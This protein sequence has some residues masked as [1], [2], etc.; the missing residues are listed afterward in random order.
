M[1]RFQYLLLVLAIALLAACKPTTSIARQNSSEADAT[2]SSD[3]FGLAGGTSGKGTPSML[4]ELGAGWI[5]I[6]VNWAQ[7]EPRPGKYNWEQVSNSVRSLAR[8]QPGVSVLVTLRAKSQWAGRGARGAPEKA[9]VPPR[10]LNAYY[11]F[12]YGMA[13][14]GKGIVKCWQ[15]ENEIESQTWWAGTPEEYIALLETA[16]R[17]IRAAD[18]SAK[19]MLAGFTS[20]MTTAAALLADGASKQEIA[21]RL[22]AKEDISDAKAEK[23]VRR[24]VDFIEAVLAQAKDLFDI[25]DIH[26]YNDYDTIPLRVEWLRG[27]MKANGYERP[28]WATEVGGPDT[29][30]ASF[31]ETYQAQEIIKRFALA[32]SAGVEKV[33]WLGLTELEG[34]GERFNHLG[35]VTRSGRKKLAYRAYQLTVAKLGSRAFQ[36]KLE[37][38]NGY[39]FRFGQGESSVWVLWADRA[40][41]YK[42]TGVPGRAVKVT[43]IE[44]QTDTIPVENGV[45]KLSLGPSPVFVE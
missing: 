30:V 33:F 20:E 22:G 27:R 4:R 21:R 17:A 9:T 11:D 43:N 45:A 18:P 40:L 5:R 24:N 12:V 38:P 35:L 14:R 2:A 41:D 32:L 29:R 19:I 7:V 26:L 44:N 31:N 1:K 10:D 23:R 15:I 6:P 36:S 8:S 3:R 39:G 28:V 16:A 34:Q 42:L 37:L 13:S 25:A